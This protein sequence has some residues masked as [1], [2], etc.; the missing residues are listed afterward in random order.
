[1]PSG[2]CTSQPP[3]GGQVGRRPPSGP[4]R[5]DEAKTVP[6][7]SDQAR[8]RGA[9]T[10]TPSRCAS[11]AAKSPSPVRQDSSVTWRPFQSGSLR[12]SAAMSSTLSRRP[13]TSTPSRSPWPSTVNVSGSGV[14]RRA[15]SRMACSSGPKNDRP[16][17]V[18]SL[19]R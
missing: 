6:S 16:A 17:G 9:T 18:L 15:R 13:F 5:A 2:R 19:S 10:G 12:I 14:T 7:E 4:G 1:M 11:R 3:S 8:P